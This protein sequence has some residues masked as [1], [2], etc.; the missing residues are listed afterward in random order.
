MQ[1]LGVN[2]SRLE[3][4]K[5]MCVGRQGKIVEI[6]SENWKTLSDQQVRQI[7]RY[8]GLLV[9]RFLSCL[10]PFQAARYGIVQSMLFSWQTPTLRMTRPLLGGRPPLAPRLLAGLY[11]VCECQLDWRHQRGNMSFGWDNPRD[12]PLPYVT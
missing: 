9:R 3:R 7:C 11:P 5:T 6:F 8:L 1:I 2:A 10:S 12:S 4:W